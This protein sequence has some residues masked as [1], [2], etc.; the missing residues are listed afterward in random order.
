MN[1]LLA[2]SIAGTELKG[3]GRGMKPLFWVLVLV[4]MSPAPLA[5]A[6]HDIGEK[7][8]ISR[9]ALLCR[10]VPFLAEV[11]RYQQ[12]NAEASVQRFINQNRCFMTRGTT[13]GTVVEFGFE[14]GRGDFVKVT[15]RGRDYW[16][17][18]RNIR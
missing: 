17:N 8:K 2:E 10:T 4:L 5:L 9:N 15:A 13:K 1:S 16:V 14:Q 12:R 7:V 3:E 11:E 6:S 18:S